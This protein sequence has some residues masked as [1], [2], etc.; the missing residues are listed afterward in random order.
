MKVCVNCFSDKELKG[1]ISSSSVIGDCAVCESNNQQLLDVSELFDF[2][3]EL[4]DNFKIEENGIPLSSKIQSNWS[5]FSTHY[6][7]NKILK[8]VL[9]KL[10]TKVI[11]LNINVE[12]PNDYNFL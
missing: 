1:F 5:F 12:F 4:V 8:Y 2:F 9:P 6:T 7:A 11:S 10:K 3:Q